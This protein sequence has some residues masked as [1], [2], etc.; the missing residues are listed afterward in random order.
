METFDGSVTE[1][2]RDMDTQVEALKRSVLKAA[3]ASPS[4]LD[5]HLSRFDFAQS[6]TKEFV[7]EL[8]PTYF[9]LIDD[10]VTKAGLQEVVEKHLEVLYKKYLHLFRLC[11]DGMG[12]KD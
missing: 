4:D 9:D 10:Q 7:V 8:I 5:Q 12:C 1:R 11:C 2:P 3:K 6:W